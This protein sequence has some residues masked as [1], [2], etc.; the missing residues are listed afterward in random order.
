MLAFSFM[1]QDANHHYAVTLT[2][3]N[4]AAEVEEPRFLSYALRMLA[5][6]KSGA[7]AV[8]RVSR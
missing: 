6:T 1:V 5:L 4:P 2:W 7:F 8:Q 3:N